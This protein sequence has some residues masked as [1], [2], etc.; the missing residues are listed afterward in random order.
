MKAIT[1]RLLAKKKLNF[2][3]ALELAKAIESAEKDTRQIQDPPST[4]VS[5]TQVHHATDRQKQRGR[6]PQKQSGMLPCFR[7]GGSHQPSKC[8]FIQAVCHGCKKRGHIVRVCRSKPNFGKTPRKGQHTIQAEENGD[9]ASSEDDSC[10]YTMFAVRNRACKPRVQT[11]SIN[12]VGVDMEMDTDA[13]Y[14]VMTQIT[15]LDS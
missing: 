8:R 14:S 7:C 10:T 5:T 3:K 6:H 1:N 11:I 2:E 12:G 4:G 9:S 13:A 15:G